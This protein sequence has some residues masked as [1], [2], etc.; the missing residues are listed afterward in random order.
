MPI[1][2]AIIQPLTTEKSSRAQE[3]K[4]YTFLV[5]KNATKNEVKSEVEALY[6]VK[7]KD[8][9]TM[10]LPKK[11]RLVGKNRVYVKRP[12]T[13]RAIVTLKDK[14]TIDPNKLKDSKKK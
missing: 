8:V 11:V 14:K 10:L 2:T 7:V 9:K 5:R 12:V 1:A 13:K 3:I 6:G 4:K